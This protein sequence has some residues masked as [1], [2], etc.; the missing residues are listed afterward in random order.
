M[1][2][3]QVFEKS[4]SMYIFCTCERNASPS[5]AQVLHLLN[6][7]R[8]HAKLTHESGTVARL[9]RSG[10]DDRRVVEELYLTFFSRFPSDEERR[11]GE[12]FLGSA[13]NRREAA[14][15]GS[16]ALRRSGP[17]ILRACRVRDG[18]WR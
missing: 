11:T 4:D 10:A 12:R 17:G 9:M 14:A 16:V 8:V 1:P 6:S 2:S 3:G 15:G 18:A 5:V 7:E 13:T